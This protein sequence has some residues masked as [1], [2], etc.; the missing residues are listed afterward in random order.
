MR[1]T[2][3]LSLVACL[4]LAGC[5]ASE[6]G[7]LLVFSFNSAKA[8]S[9]TELGFGKAVAE[10]TDPKVLAAFDECVERSAPTKETRQPVPVA[11]GN[12][13]VICRGDRESKRIALHIFADGQISWRYENALVINGALAQGDALAKS[14]AQDKCCKCRSIKVRFESAN[15]DAVGSVTGRSSLTDYNWAIHHHSQATI[16]QGKL[17][18][19]GR[20]VK[21]PVTKSQ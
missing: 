6:D 8:I 4:L 2:I 21:Y 10:I 20:E 5:S 19:N 7:R 18:E 16:F 3:Q 15:D 14:C 11:N 1:C 17:P 9:Q 12:W 13:I